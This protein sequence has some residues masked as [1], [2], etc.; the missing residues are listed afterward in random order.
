[1]S[2]NTLNGALRRMGYSGDEM[3]AHGIRASLSILANENGL[4]HLDAIEPSLAHVDKNEGRRAYA[5]SDHWLNRLPDYC[6]LPCR[7][8]LAPSG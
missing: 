8:Y 4:W 6:L 3:T 2:E 5:R 7:G 1:M